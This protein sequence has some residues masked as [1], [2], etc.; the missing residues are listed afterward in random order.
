MTSTRLPRL[1]ISAL[2]LISPT[3]GAQQSQQQQENARTQ[4]AKEARDKESS[5]VRESL[6]RV[7][8]TPLERLLSSGD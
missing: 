8:N 3:L 2:L 5:R 7:F 1:L 6:L 4:E